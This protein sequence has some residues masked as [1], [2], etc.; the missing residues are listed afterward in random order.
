MAIILTAMT[1]HL[2]G[3]RMARLLSGQKGVDNLSYEKL[4]DALSI[5]HLAAKR[6]EDILTLRP[7]MKQVERDKRRR[8]FP[9]ST[10][11]LCLG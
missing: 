8:K 6:W 9:V 5:H 3:M 1:N 4:Y 7:F 2:I 10:G 11:A